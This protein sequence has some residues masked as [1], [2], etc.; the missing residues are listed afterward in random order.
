MTK[1]I[2]VKGITV[3]GAPAPFSMKGWDTAK[4]KVTV[5]VN[6]RNCYGALIM[7]VPHTVC[8]CCVLVVVQ[9]HCCCEGGSR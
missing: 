9:H 8:H 2:K 3:A 1:F 7:T 4:E 5:E 6:I